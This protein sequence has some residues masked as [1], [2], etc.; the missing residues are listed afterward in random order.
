[1]R[2]AHAALARTSTARIGACAAFAWIILPPAP[3]PARATDEPA[4]AA[5]APAE[6]PLEQRCGELAAALERLAGARRAAAGAD[7]L[8]VVEAEEIARVAD[9]ILAEGDAALA[10]DL[11][12]E[13]LALLAPER[14]TP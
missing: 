13:A 2:C 7:S 5:A 6:V 14:E 9:E 12:E 3:V 11:L 4:D 10:H 1:M 8:A